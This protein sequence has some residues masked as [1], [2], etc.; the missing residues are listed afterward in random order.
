MRC[1]S[2]TCLDDKVVDTRISRDG[3]AIRR[4]RECTR[5][6]NRFTTY[7]TYLRAE[8]TVV[9]RDGTR[10]DLNPEKL[11]DGIRHACWKRPVSE[12]E[13]DQVVR[14]VIDALEKVQDREIPSQSL[15]QMVMDELKQVDHVA[16]VRFA[17][18]YR[19]FEDIGEFLDTIKTLT[20]RQKLNSGSE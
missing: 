14:N 19:R 4:R 13:I 2:C 9:K 11:R 17:S 5:C 6:G 7:E 18:V 1:P 8:L 3:D 20:D 12:G 16:Y 10:E 15:G